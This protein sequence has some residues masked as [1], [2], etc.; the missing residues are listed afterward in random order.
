MGASGSKW[1]QVGASG[2]SGLH[3]D[4]QKLAAAVG[5]IKSIVLRHLTIQSDSH[6][7]VIVLDFVRVPKEFRTPGFRAKR[8]KRMRLWSVM[9]SLQG[10]TPGLT[11]NIVGLQGSKEYVVNGQGS[12]SSDMIYGNIRVSLVFERCNLDGV[13]RYVVKTTTTTT[14]KISSMPLV[15]LASHH[16]LHVSCFY[17]IIILNFKVAS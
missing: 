6:S 14:T 7:K 17:S 10:S 12:H 3:R 2:H 11:P 15:I 4:E 13:L 5:V 1:E 9:A 16:P 8:Q